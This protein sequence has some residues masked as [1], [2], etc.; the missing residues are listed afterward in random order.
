MADRL[1]CC[2]WG[3]TSADR[4]RARS[5]ENYSHG[6]RTRPRSRQTLADT[7]DTGRTE[8]EGWWNA[9]KPNSRAHDSA[10]LTRFSSAARPGRRYTCCSSAF[11]PKAKGANELAQRKS[12][13]KLRSIRARRGRASV[14]TAAGILLALLG[15]RVRVL[16]APS[17]ENLAGVA[18]P[19]A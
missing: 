1:A 19:G 17:C 11:P 16:A 14:A 3:K 6:G 4:D 18:M 2:D 9:A 7:T 12:A 5:G 13:M 10:L 15:A 8:S